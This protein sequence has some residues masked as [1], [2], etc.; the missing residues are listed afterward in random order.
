MSKIKKVFAFIASNGI[1]LATLG[2]V[3]AGGA[4]GLLLRLR[5]EPYTPREVMYISYIGKLFLNML[6]CIIIPL[7]VPSLMASIGSLDLSLSGKVGGR[8]IVYYLST[9]LC[10]VFLGITLVS[11][12]RPGEGHN[13]VADASKGRNVTTADTLMDL[14][15]NAFPANVIQ[16]TMQQYQTVLVYPGDND[17]AKADWPFK[18]NYT[19]STNIIGLIVFSVVIGIAIASSG[20]EGEPFPRVCESVS[21]VM[22]KVTE[23]VMN[24]APIGVCFLIAGQIAGMKNFQESM[25]K[26]GW[27]FSTIM[28]GFSIHGLLTLPLIYALVTKTLPFRFILN[29][30]SALVTAFSTGSSSATLPVTI[31]A[32]EHNNKVDKRICNFLLPIG[33]TINMDGTALYEA[34]AAIFIAQAYGM[35]LTFGRI[36]VISITATAASIGAAGI[37]QG[38]LVTI[39][40]VLDTLGL[41]MEGVSLI[42]AVDWLIDRFRTAVNVLGDAIGAGVV[43]HLSKPEMELILTEEEQNREIKMDEDAIAIVAQNGKSH[44]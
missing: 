29:M 41:P 31:E 23:W 25:V 4:L 16:A 44:A 43:Y 7:I 42:L 13:Q 18:A 28:I 11:T 34:V 14:V 17:I 26:L 2:G 37:P 33:A 5:E 27:Y 39:F 3:V 20:K 38:G 22:M 36:I 12:I 24:L 35:S 9:T 8:A 6:K 32:L 21:T 19:N 1:T 15:R 10:A 40:M 30:G